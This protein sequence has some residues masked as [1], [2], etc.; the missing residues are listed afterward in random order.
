M[1]T[2]PNDAAFRFVKQAERHE[3]AKANPSHRTQALWSLMTSLIAA[4]LAAVYLAD[5]HYIGVVVFALMMLVNLR[6]F[7]RHWPWGSK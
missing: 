1:Q 7:F 5:R 4:I 3:A 6:Q 2:N